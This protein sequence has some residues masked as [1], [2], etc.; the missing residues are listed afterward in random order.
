MENELKQQKNTFLKSIMR[1]PKL[2]KTLGSAISAPIGSTKRVQA[3]STLSIM[4][5]LGRNFN[6]QGGIFGTP[7]SYTGP[8]DF[9]KT[10]LPP[11]IGSIPQKPITDYS[12]MVIFPAAPAFKRP[13]SRKALS[14]DPAGAFTFPK[15]AQPTIKSTEDLSKITLPEWTPPSPLVSPTMK[16]RM[17]H[18]EPGFAG[19][20]YTTEEVP[21]PR[22][23]TPEQ[24]S[25][26]LRAGVFRTGPLSEIYGRRTPAEK[27]S[28]AL[29]ERPEEV[30]GAE[31][32]V[33][34]PSA[35]IPTYAPQVPTYQEGVMGDAQRARDTGI[36]PHLFA[37]QIADEQFGG[38]VEA[39]LDD[40]GEGI[41]QCVGI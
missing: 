17:Y 36:P 4:D 11:A 8:V 12:N 35:P 3:K 18:T 21:D 32:P 6:S 30:R 34:E 5:K 13:V 24:R 38:S 33:Y 14:T 7:G 16:K 41:Y 29:M 10:V 19:G 1:D 20:Y 39:Y 25:A 22:Y 15:L 40:F 26:L 9:S 27:V 37:K 23:K 31:R 2:S 28:G